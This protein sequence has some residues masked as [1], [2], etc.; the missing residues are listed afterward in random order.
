MKSFRNKDINQKIFTQSS[1]FKALKSLKPD[2]SLLSD[3]SLLTFGFTEM[4]CSNF[5]IH[6][7]IVHIVQLLCGFK[8]RHCKILFSD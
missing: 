1:A 6:L 3:L 8:N 7:F 5:K 2:S 4:S